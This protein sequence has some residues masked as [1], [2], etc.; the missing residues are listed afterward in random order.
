MK[1]VTFYATSDILC[2]WYFTGQFLQAADRSSAVLGAFGIWHSWKKEDENIF[3]F[4]FFKRFLE[5]FCIDILNRR[6]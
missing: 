5:E 1:N 3:I 4:L 6:F 2:F